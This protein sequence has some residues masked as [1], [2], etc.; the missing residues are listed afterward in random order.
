M[1]AP[2]KAARGGTRCTSA[3]TVVSTMRGAAAGFSSRRVR[4]A[5]R[6]D[7]SAGLGETRS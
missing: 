7:T 2:A 1:L 5:T 4:V 6:S 3:F